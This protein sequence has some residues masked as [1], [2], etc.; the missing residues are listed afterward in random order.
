MSRRASH[1]HQPEDLSALPL[2]RRD[3]VRATLMAIAIV[4]VIVFLCSLDGVG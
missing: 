2:V 1:A 4:A 3:D